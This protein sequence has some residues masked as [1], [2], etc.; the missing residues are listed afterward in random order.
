M[1]LGIILKH[2]SCPA[3]PGKE[4]YDRKILR[5]GGDLVPAAERPA[6]SSPDAEVD[7]SKLR[8]TVITD[9]ARREAARLMPSACGQPVTAIRSLIRFLV[10]ES[11]VPEG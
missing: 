7:W 11:L 4:K 2:F 9:F 3:E 5:A 6:W 1:L 8:A 10:A